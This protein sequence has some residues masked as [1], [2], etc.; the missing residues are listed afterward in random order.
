MGERVDRDEEFL[1]D[2][3]RTEIDQS[4][5]PNSES[6]QFQPRE[7]EQ[8]RRLLDGK[9]IS[10]AAGTTHDSTLR[11]MAHARD[12]F[13]VDNDMQFDTLIDTLVGVR[14][15]LSGDVVIQ[16]GRREWLGVESINTEHAS[17]QVGTMYVTTNHVCFVSK[18]KS[19]HLTKL[20]RRPR[21]WG[22]IHI[23]DIFEAN[24]Q[25]QEGMLLLE[26]VF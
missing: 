3:Y 23:N 13:Q 22:K 16:S 20:A 8:L 12:V 6:A 5:K 19:T 15:M 14:A 1:C 2:R 17:Y 26:L 7:H 9:A 18:A 4:I 21:L 24:R 10:A 25:G 11:N